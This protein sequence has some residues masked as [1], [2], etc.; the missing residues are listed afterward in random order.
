[1]ETSSIIINCSSENLLRRDVILSKSKT[2]N[3][4]P[5]LILK[6]DCIIMPFTLILVIQLGA[7]IKARGLSGEPP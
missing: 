6:A 1:M 3:F 5:H 7:R 2:S 4:P